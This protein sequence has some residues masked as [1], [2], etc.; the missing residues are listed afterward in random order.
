MIEVFIPIG[1][2]GNE[3]ELRYVLRSLE[4]NITVPF[5]VTLGVNEKLDWF[6]GEQ[7]LVERGPSIPLENYWD[8][9]KKLN[10]YCSTHSGDF[11]L[12]YDDICL[13]KPM[14]DFTV[15]DN[16]ALD[17]ADKFARK[18]FE[19][20][21]HGNTILKA[22]ELLPNK[23]YFCY[24]T[25]CPRLMNCHL[26]LD[27][28]EKF[29]IFE[30][31]IPPAPSTLYYGYYYAHPFKILAENNDIRASFCMEDGDAT[32]SYLA[33]K[34]GDFAKYSADKVILHWNQKVFN[35]NIGGKYILRD[36][37]NKLFPNKSHY[38][39]M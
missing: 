8:V 35:L 12:W 21:K 1:G 22:F 29:N 10:A 24:E 30:Q 4:T 9:W 23:H 18:E 15:F 37:L 20:Y 16:L 13:I 25:H 27:L 38:E 17:R 6:Q 34:E 5:D 7:L 39:R 19:G 33:T 28:I 36:Y 31:D 2:P 32:G 11:V 14:H 3:L 26:V